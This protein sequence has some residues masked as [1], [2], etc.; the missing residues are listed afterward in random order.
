MALRKH[1]TRVRRPKREQFVVTMLEDAWS[2]IHD[3]LGRS[4]LRVLRKATGEVFNCSIDAFEQDTARLTQ[5]GDPLPKED[6]YDIVLVG[7]VAMLP[8]PTDPRKKE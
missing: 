3:A 7:R 8:P 4:N 5:F 6:G 2:V 1:N